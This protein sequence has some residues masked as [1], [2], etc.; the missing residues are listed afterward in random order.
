VIP[1]L[2]CNSCYATD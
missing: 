1:P 2:I